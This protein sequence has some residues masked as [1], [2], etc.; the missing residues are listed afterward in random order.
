MFDRFTDSAWRLACSACTPLSV[1]VAFVSALTTVSMTL[2]VPSLATVSRVLSLKKTTSSS[3][4]TIALFHTVA[5]SLLTL[6]K[7]FVIRCKP[8]SLSLSNFTLFKVLSLWNGFPWIGLLKVATSSSPG[9]II[10]IRYC[11]FVSIGLRC[12]INVVN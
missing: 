2:S 8:V 10:V 4:Q 5:M 11:L 7:V 12:I 1:L 9:S 6:S 3:I